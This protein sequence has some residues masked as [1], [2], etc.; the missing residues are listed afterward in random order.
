MR[1]KGLGFKS[2]LEG[3]PQET[4]AACLARPRA[5]SL[6]LMASSKQRR[7]SENKISDQSVKPQTLNPTF[8]DLIIIVLAVHVTGKSAATSG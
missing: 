5:C 1:I 8:P 3:G 4:D 6:R 7:N 2:F